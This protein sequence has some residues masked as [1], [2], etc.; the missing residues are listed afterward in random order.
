GLEPAPAV[1]AQRHAS[2]QERREQDGGGPAHHRAGP[3]RSAS[4]RAASSGSCTSSHG[5]AY[6]G[7]CAAK[8][9]PTCVSTS[10]SSKNSHIRSCR[11]SV[12]SSAK[13][14]SQVAA[15]FCTLWS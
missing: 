13:I 3:K 2:A 4:R 12:L 1:E 6:C 10:F 9:A 5:N 8:V 7:R 11:W 14:R 15:S